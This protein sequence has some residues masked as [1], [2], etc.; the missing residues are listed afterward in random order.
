MAQKPGASKQSLSTKTDASFFKKDSKLPVKSSDSSKQQDSAATYSQSTTAST[1]KRKA[2]SHLSPSSKPVKQQAKPA[3]VAIS[4]SFN[5]NE[6]E[7]DIQ[8]GSS[9][10]NLSVNQPERETLPKAIARPATP[11]GGMDLQSELCD[12]QN[13]NT[14]H[15]VYIKCADPSDNIVLRIQAKPIEFQQKFDQ[16]F[17][18]A[19]SI[20]FHFKNKCIKVT[21]SASQKQDLMQ[22]EMIA[23]IPVIPSL[24]KT[25]IPHPV[26]P[27]AVSHNER[28]YK[29]VIN[30]VAS[31]LNESDLT[32]QTNATAARRLT[33]FDQSL[34]QRVPSSTVVLSFSDE[35]PSTVYI[36]Y[37]AFATK[38]YVPRPIRCNKCQQYGHPT[39][40]CKSSAI[41]CSY[42]SRSHTYEQC[43]YKD[44]PDIYKPICANCGGAHSAAYSRCPKFLHVKE[45]L[46]VR[47]T[48]H[49]NFKEA[50]LRTAPSA[51]T[52]AYTATG[53]TQFSSIAA[54]QSADS[55]NAYHQTTT[56]NKSDIQK[57]QEAFDEQSKRID[58][59]TTRMDKLHQENK[60]LIDDFGAMLLETQQQHKSSIDSL[61]LKHLT[62]FESKL[63]ARY[64]AI[65]QDLKCIQS[66]MDSNRPPPQSAS[67]NRP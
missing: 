33:R 15:V 27:S 35:P 37:L 57:L 51:V 26:P 48:E 41:R 28:I 42:C 10:I 64:T 39:Q 9:I 19:H 50:L 55:N 17:G 29:C 62:S 31:H 43:T 38:P 30:N 11:I 22:T 18:K 4:S 52:S 1:G 36:G 46:H 34:K 2:D 59:L 7:N 12:D 14:T 58:A 6:I 25:N 13:D 61:I 54:V 66:C 60:K 63:Q 67:H 8:D 56:K 23:G 5:R 49:L 47:A 20:D 53:S 24:P 40:T 32:Y 16:S 44:T 65:E 21:C 45:A 3:E